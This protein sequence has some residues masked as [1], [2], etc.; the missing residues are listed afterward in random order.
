[1]EKLNRTVPAYERRGDGPPLILVGSTSGTDAGAGEA[2]LA[3]LLAPRFTTY[4]YGRRG[5]AAELGD[6][7][8]LIA[9][10]GGSA[11]VH[12]TASGGALAL[13]AAAAGLPIR[14][15]SAYEPPYGAALAPLVGARAAAP[16]NPAP[17]CAL[18]AAVTARVLVLDGGASPARTRDTAR[19]VAAAVPRARHTTLTGQTHEV[20][21]QVLAPVL[22]RF[23]AEAA[24]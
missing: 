3:R 11:Y 2:A 6:L 22:G 18:L 12:G 15:L 17:P 14:R 19:A 23:F 4:T 16:G 10:A 24:D 1:M 8:A 9:E 5:G 21:P 7:A 20:A 13:E